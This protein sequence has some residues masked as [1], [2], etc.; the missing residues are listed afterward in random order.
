MAE[1]KMDSPS[2]LGNNSELR[3][4]SKNV[5]AKSSL[6]ARPHYVSLNYSNTLTRKKDWSA[7]RKVAF[8]ICQLINTI[9]T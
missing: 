5:S 9:Q 7:D 4:V 1:P 3:Y 8:A 6:F 2:L